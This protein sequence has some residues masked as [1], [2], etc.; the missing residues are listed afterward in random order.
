MK[1]FSDMTIRER[2]RLQFTVYCIPI[3]ALLI[4][5]LAVQHWG[6]LIG[7]LIATAGNVMFLLINEKH[8]RDDPPHANY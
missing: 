4:L 1:R 6:M 3:G 5:G 2:G 7:A 8:T